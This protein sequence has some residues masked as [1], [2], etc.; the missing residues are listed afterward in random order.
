VI[1]EQDEVA[2]TVFAREGGAWVTRFLGAGEMLAMP[3]IGAELALDELYEGVGLA[4]PDA[5]RA[6]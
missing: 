4:P 3:E 6:G 2:A 5:A 1:F